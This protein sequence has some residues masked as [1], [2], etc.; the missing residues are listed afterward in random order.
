MSFSEEHQWKTL[1][2][3]KWHGIWTKTQLFSNTATRSTTSTGTQLRPPSH[4]FPTVRVS[5]WLSQPVAPWWEEFLSKSLMSVFITIVIMSRCVLKKLALFSLSLASG[6]L[7]L[8]SSLTGGCCCQLFMICFVSI[9][10][11]VQLCKLLLLSLWFQTFL[12]VGKNSTPGSIHPIHAC[13]SAGWGSEC[14]AKVNPI[15]KNTF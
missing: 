8:L 10:V 12:Q 2:W 14:G 15:E 9:F 11:K 1:H 6:S 7:P 5:W 13:P 3:T 4:C